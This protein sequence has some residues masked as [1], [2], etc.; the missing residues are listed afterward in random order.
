MQQF[1]NER[2]LNFF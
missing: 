2:I 1:E